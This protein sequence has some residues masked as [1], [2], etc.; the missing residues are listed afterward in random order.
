MEPTFAS[1]V[2]ATAV[3]VLIQHVRVVP[4]ESLDFLLETKSC[5]F[6]EHVVA[7][8]PEL[9]MPL[10]RP[11]YPIAYGLDHVLLYHFAI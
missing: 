6:H 3:D 5:V 2:V 7:A 4:P 1:C 11:S 10:D 8:V 9:S